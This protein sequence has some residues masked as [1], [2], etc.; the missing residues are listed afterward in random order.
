MGNRDVTTIEVS[1]DTHQ[2][3][4]DMKPYGSMSFDDLVRELAQ[5]SDYVQGEI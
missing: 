1:R 2:M 5:T 4:A 3:L